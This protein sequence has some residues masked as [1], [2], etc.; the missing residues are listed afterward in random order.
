MEGETSGA[1]APL[2]VG[3]RAGVRIGIPGRGI[4]VIAPGSPG[5]HPGGRG[6]NGI[7]TAISGCQTFLRMIQ[8][9]A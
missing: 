4:V 9:C 7:V 2:L 1:P 8:C 5:E 3:E 6:V